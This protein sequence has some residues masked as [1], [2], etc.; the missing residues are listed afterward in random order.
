M[1]HGLRCKMKNYKM[2]RNKI[3]E[4]SSGSWAR[5]QILG[6]HPESTILK[7]KSLYIGL[8]KNEK[9]FAVQKI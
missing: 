5:Q 9:L 4:K 6:L 3:I 8:H 7:G 2:F 1:Y